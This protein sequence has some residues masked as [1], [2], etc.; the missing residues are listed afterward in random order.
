LLRRILFAQRP[1]LPSGN[2]PLMAVSRYD[3][4]KGV[5]K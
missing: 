5:P 1:Q 4:T 2:C 3:R